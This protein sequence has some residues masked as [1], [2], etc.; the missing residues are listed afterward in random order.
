M[1]LFDSGV[2]CVFEQIWLL[3]VLV[4][5]RGWGESMS[6]VL[7]FSDMNFGNYIMGCCCW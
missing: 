4:M 3:Q 7:K 5:I 1:K 6:L 2:D